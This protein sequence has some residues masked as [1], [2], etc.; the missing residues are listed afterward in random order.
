M[1]LNVVNNCFFR[2]T[3]KADKNY[4]ADAKLCEKDM[5]K[6]GIISLVSWMK[7]NIRMLSEKDRAVVC[8][9]IRTGMSLET[10]KLSFKQFPAEDIEELY[11]SESGAK[12]D[13]MEGIGNISCNCS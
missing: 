8:N 4:V 5:S 12:Y 11:N 3:F 6:N 1:D 13:E 2:M 9:F 10:L 7:E